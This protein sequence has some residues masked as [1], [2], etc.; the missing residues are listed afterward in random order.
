MLIFGQK[1]L[2]TGSSPQILV[3][4]SPD[5]EDGRIILS[6]QMQTPQPFAEGGI[7]GSFGTSLDAAAFYGIKTDNIF[8]SAYSWEISLDS[9]SRGNFVRTSALSN[10][11]TTAIED[12]TA[13]NKC[14]GMHEM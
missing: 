6:M 4:N 8:P 7:N 1:D 9:S 13:S 12:S 3:G 14:V 5:L 11:S 2:L 10:T